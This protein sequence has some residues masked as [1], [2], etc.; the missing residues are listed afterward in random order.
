MDYI[1]MWNLTF[2]HCQRFL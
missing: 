2:P 1:S